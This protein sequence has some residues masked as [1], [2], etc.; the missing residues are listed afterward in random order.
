MLGC[1]TPQKDQIMAS[2]NA[3]DFYNHRYDERCVPTGPVGCVATNTALKAWKK[4]LN[5]ADVVLVRGGA[6]PLQVAHVKKLQKEA[7]KC[8]P[9]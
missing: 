2:V 3:W 6:I 4:S 5:E 1:A 7:K 9:K 8:L